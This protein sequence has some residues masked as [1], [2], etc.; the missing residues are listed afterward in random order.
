MSNN[1]TRKRKH[2][3][4]PAR[5]WGLKPEENYND[6]GGATYVVSGH[7]VSGSGSG[8]GMFVGESLGREV[9]A[10]AARKMA[11]RE[12]EKALSQ[13]LMRD[14]EGMQA[15]VKAREAALKNKEKASGKRNENTAQKG[16]R[17]EAEVKCGEVGLE[18]DTR[19]GGYSAAIIK[20][21]GFDPSAKVGQGP[22]AHDD[23]VNHSAA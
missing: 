18:K 2:E 3:Y 11:G 14:K 17:K 8:S 4:D 20:N 7:V 22:P 12:T 10:K 13:L 16:K 5:S 23:K 6:G 19:R 1:A 9:Q 21:L 15:V